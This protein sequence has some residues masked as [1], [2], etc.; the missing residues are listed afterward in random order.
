MNKAVAQVRQSR[1]ESSEKVGESQYIFERMSDALNLM[2]GVLLPLSD[3]RRAERKTAIRD[4]DV[5]RTRAEN[6]VRR[7]YGVRGGVCVCV[8]I[9]EYVIWNNL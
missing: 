9:P 3:R 7:E 4:G 6:H 5:S 1:A 8:M 2:P